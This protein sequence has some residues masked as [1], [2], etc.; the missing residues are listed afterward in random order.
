M[1]CSVEGNPV[2]KEFHLWFPNK[3]YKSLF[4]FDDWGFWGDWFCM[5]TLLEREIHFYPL[6]DPTFD[7]CSQFYK[8][9]SW[10]GSRN[11]MKERDVWLAKTIF[12]DPPLYRVSI[13]EKV[14]DF[15]KAKL[16]PETSQ[17]VLQDVGTASLRVS[18]D[19]YWIYS[20]LRSGKG[21]DLYCYGLDGE[22]VVVK[23]APR[24]SSESPIDL[25]THNRYW[26]VSYS[27]KDKIIFNQV[28]SDKKSP[29]E[30]QKH[31]FLFLESFPEELKKEEF[32]IVSLSSDPS[33]LY[34]ILL[35]ASRICT[36]IYDLRNSKEASKSPPKFVTQFFR[37]EATP[38]SSFQG[39]YLCWQSDLGVV[40]YTKSGT[41]STLIPLKT[42]EEEKEIPKV[43]IKKIEK[44]VHVFV[45]SK[46]HAQIGEWIFPLISFQ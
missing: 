3:R 2:S 26:M 4:W 43:M 17:R 36:Q 28:L 10:F 32:K 24:P 30:K 9:V 41:K 33:C 25:F 46:C 16:F 5:F 12:Y 35:S 42:E 15:G 38:M 21:D 6:C 8:Q 22:R 7:S 40:R 44:S 29:V 18:G 14:K 19:E 39:N 13:D 27:Q 20:L 23:L 31:Y 37:T 45:A 11:S 1:Y 34:V